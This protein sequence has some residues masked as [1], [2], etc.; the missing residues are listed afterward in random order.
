MQLNSEVV[1]R[2]RLAIS[3]RVGSGIIRR[4]PPRVFPR[5]RKAPTNLRDGLRLCH[6]AAIG[7]F[8][9]RNI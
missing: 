6:C 1:G 9:R 7:H 5:A 3:P 4:V 8:C 2:A